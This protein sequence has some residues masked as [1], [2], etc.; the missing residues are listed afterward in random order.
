MKVCAVI[1]TYGDRFRL[2]IQVV[3]ACLR[4]GVEKI[5]VVDNNSALSSLGKLRELKQKERKLQ[6]IYLDEN[7][8]SA[9]G[10]K[11]G[12]QEAYKC[13]DCEVIWLLDNDD[14]P[15]KEFLK[16]L[17]KFWN[18]LYGESKEER[19]SLLSYRADG[20]VFIKRLLY[21]ITNLLIGRKNILGLE[22]IRNYGLICEGIGRKVKSS[23][24]QKTK[25]IMSF[26]VV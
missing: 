9:G 19:V 13:K 3:N 1:V 16:L 23:T 20:V 18:N 25:T 11:I 15:Q 2:L 8:G 6:V 4:E 21:T 24:C 12:L 17:K 22:V 7:K 10:Y 5:I 14:E 26:A